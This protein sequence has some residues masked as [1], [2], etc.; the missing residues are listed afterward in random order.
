VPSLVA[1]FEA[2]LAA[3]SVIGAT[4]KS[5]R[6]RSR[7]VAVPLLPLENTSE[8]RQKMGKYITKTGQH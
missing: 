8:K 2:A 1:A 3:E 6:A 7:S 4:H 5:F